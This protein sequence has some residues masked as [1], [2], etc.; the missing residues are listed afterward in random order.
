MTTVFPEASRLKKF[1]VLGHLPWSHPQPQGPTGKPNYRICRYVDDILVLVAGT[2]EDAIAI[3]AWVAEFLSLMGLRLSPEKT[4]I[5]HVDEG[6]DFLG[7]RLQR[8]S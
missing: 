8:R 5:T 2:R 7:W 3:R 4:K 6:L 1:G